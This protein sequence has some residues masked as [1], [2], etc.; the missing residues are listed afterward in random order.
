[1]KRKESTPTR[2]RFTGTWLMNV[3]RETAEMMAALAG[4]RQRAGVIRGLIRQA[5]EEKYGKA[6]EATPAATG[7]TL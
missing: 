3:D 7:E 6:A 4:P 2:A 1:M 5:Y